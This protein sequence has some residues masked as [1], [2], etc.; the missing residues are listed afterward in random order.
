M[1]ISM[2]EMKRRLGVETSA[3]AVA[4]RRRNSEDCRKL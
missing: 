2:A 3:I 4:I 1:G